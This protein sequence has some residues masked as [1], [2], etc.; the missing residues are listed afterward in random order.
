MSGPGAKRE[1]R[2]E[3]LA[4]RLAVVAVAVGLETVARDL[5]IDGARLPADLRD[6]IGR[7]EAA[8]DRLQRHLRRFGTVLGEH[9]YDAARRVS[10]KRRERPAQHFDALR[11]HEA[12]AGGLPLAVRH[13]DGDVVLVQP[14]AANAEVR[15]R[16]E[17]ADR[18]H[19]VLRVI[20]AVLNE[21][22]RDSGERF[23][24]VDLQLTLLD[25]LRVDDVDRRGDVECPLRAARCGHDHR[26]EHRGGGL[27]HGLRCGDARRNRGQ[28]G[29][30]RARLSKGLHRVLLAL[31]RKQS[32]AG[33][34]RIADRS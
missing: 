23:R 18:K 15:A 26:I 33:L 31:S 28:H 17:P 12:E 2:V 13:R 20:P 11:R 5:E 25:L 3:E 1:F 14:H 19:Q 10:I 7:P 24:K 22:A 27:R 9:R 16:A 4:P 21:H 8:A 29:V 30:N 34:C 6:E 32:G